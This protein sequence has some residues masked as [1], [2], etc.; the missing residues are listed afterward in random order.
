[1]KM[2]IVTVAA[3]SDNG[4]AITFDSGESLEVHETFQTHI[5]IHNDIVAKS[6]GEADPADM[7]MTPEDA[8]DGNAPPLAD[9]EATVSPTC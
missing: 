1:M 9:K 5:T 2:H 6:R 3:C 8:G 4:S 7:H